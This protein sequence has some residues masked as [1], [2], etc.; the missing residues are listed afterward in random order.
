MT[1]GALLLTS[2]TCLALGILCG[3]QAPRGWLILTLAGAGLAL[4]ASGRVLFAADA[5]EWHSAM[6]IAGEHA[7]LR[8]D[9][10][11]AFFLALLS[12]VGGAAALYTRD[13]WN[14]RE[15]PR[16]AGRNR[17]CWNA[18]L[19]S[20]GAVLLCSNGLHFLI[21]W[22]L[23]A[24]CSYFL[25]TL[26]REKRE[27]RAA[28]WLYLA[29][30]HAG[31]LCLFAFFA[32]LA[33]RTGSWD[34]G[35]MHGRPELG[36]LFWLALFGFGVKAGMFPL[37]IWLP[38]AHA[39]APSHVSALLSGVALKMG[40]YG[41]IRF[42][43]WLAVPS[44]A[45][46]TVI[47][48][49][50][51]TAL[52][53][54]AFALGQTDMK[55]LLAYS[56]VENIGIILVGIG[57]GLIGITHPNETWGRLAFAGAL[58]HVWNHGLFKCLLF[59]G[60]GSVLHATGTRDMSRLGGLWR[61]MPWTAALFAL[62]SIAVCALPPLN[63]FVSEWLIYLGLFNAATGHTSAAWVAM[64]AAIMLGVTGALA[65]AAFVKAASTLFLGA[66]RTAAARHAHE[67]GP[68]MRGP[69]IFLALGCV[70]LGLAP[71]LVWPAIARTVET[72]HPAWIAAEAAP[73]VAILSPVQGGIAAVAVLCAFILWSV[74]R[75]R[76]V[77]PGPTWD[78]GYAVPTARMQYTAGSFGDT[79][80]HWFRWILQPELRLRRPR[81]FFPSEASRM[82]RVPET[83]LERG[84]QPVAGV[85]LRIST[86]VRSLQH[87][88]LQFYIAYIVAGLLGLAALVA[89]GVKP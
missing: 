87:G 57:G 14:D 20:M 17:M 54:I 9:G 49:G 31:T 46:W 35:P 28:G 16:S 45:G 72:W 69:M 10:V 74:A 77:R 48:F 71:L 56:S 33:S 58:L 30:S 89:T 44:A 84:I 34:L 82:D 55:R 19:L 5:W 38:S 4:A 8:L 32:L 60:A 37:H 75:H 70:T 88:R 29:A 39:N 76:G 79:A 51:I 66:P 81:G 36:A 53:G 61:T 85:I 18:M 27:V 40:I 1:P 21:C 86:A 24:V 42:G 62:G 67:A 12:L 59:F 68:W 23:F 22:E 25:I 47:S 73:T 63:G 80:A 7:H 11:S 13:Y 83:V 41:I 78:C 6:P 65:L 2:A 15:Y 26:E 50:A 64:P 3:R 52:L 43:G